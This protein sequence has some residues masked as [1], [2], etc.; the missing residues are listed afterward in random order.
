MRGIQDFTF[1][2]QSLLMH[3]RIENQSDR[4]EY[5]GKNLDSRREHGKRH[6]VNVAVGN[7]IVHYRNAARDARGKKQ[8]KDARKKLQRPI[9]PKNLH[10]GPQHFGSI[11]KRVQLREAPRGA[12]FVLDRDFNDAEP[13]IQRV[14]REI[15]LYLE[16]AHQ[17][18]V[19]LD[20][21]AIEHAIA[22]H[23]V[24][25]LGTEQDIDQ[26]LYQPI[27]QPMQGS[28]IFLLVV[29]LAVAV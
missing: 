19:V 20:Q 2:S 28:R 13:F 25:Q 1:K 24:D 29:T 16:A 14:Q 8:E 11:G 3:Q 10:D 27:A 9:V 21:S 23:D 6:V 12:V 7:P 4:H 17:D 26:T 22:A 5:H 15:G 18:G